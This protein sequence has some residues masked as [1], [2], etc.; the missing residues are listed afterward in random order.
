MKNRIVIVDISKSVPPA[1]SPVVSTSGG[2]GSRKA[3]CRI[4]SSVSGESALWT[5]ESGGEGGQT[6]GISAPSVY[7]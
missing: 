3:Q 1:D 7:V 5:G 6:G 4:I 2:D